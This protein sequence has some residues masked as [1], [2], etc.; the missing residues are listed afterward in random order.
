MYFAIASFVACT[1]YDLFMLLEELLLET[2]S[3]SSIG[4]ASRKLS[5]ISNKEEVGSP[6]SIVQSESAIPKLSLNVSSKQSLKKS[7]VT[8]KDVGE[9]YDTAAV[10][11]EDER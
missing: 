5:S 8:V 2:I 10:Y 9:G 3:F 4:E 11:Q 1:H 7:N 6:T